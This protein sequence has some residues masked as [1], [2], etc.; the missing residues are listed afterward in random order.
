[1]ALLRSRSRY[2]RLIVVAAILLGLYYISSQPALKTSS[3]S[4]SI[5]AASM[6]RC[7][8][9]PDY[10]P[11]PRSARKIPPDSAHTHEHDIPDPFPL[12][13][14]IPPPSLAELNLAGRESKKTH[15]PETPLLIG[16][17]RNWPQLLQCVVSYLAAGW[18][19]GDI[20]VVEN[21]GVMHANRDGRLGLQ[22]PFYLSHTQL[23]MLGVRVVVTPTLFTF[24]Q[25]Q[26][27]YAWTALE[28]NWTEYFWSHQDL[29]VFSPENSTRP[30]DTL[31][32]RAASILSYLRQPGV[33]RWANHFFAYDHL[34][35]VRRDAILDVGGW[36]THIPYYA[37]DCD[38]Y[39][40]LM[41][42]GY[43]QGET[44]I[45]II[46]D[47]A[48][49]M[50]DVGALLRIP[51]IYAAFQGDPGPENEANQDYPPEEERRRKL[52]GEHG[53]TWDHLVEI[54]RR[55]ENVKYADGGG[56]RN[57][58]QLRQ[59]GG[60]GE[61]F[62]RDPEGFE[63]G[64]RMMIDT[65]RSVF[66]EKWGHRGCDI[67]EIGLGAEDAWKVER[68]WDPETEGGGSE[69]DDW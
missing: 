58:W 52:I 45:G 55:M 65:G 51:G 31:H 18:P 25:L 26:N 64:L 39:D 44:N 56:W 49:V 42:A 57:M 62:Y 27:F 66:A 22:N 20:W 40:R 13:S 17:T 2:G 67:A 47:V 28:R 48:S 23:E 12:L 15:E 46:L 36:D 53:E 5:S 59:T 7:W 41:W 11:R 29:L 24:A 38:M 30:E 9:P 61:P 35:L 63:T 50:D 68:D 14:R 54:G 8:K 34:T 21:T 6:I 10:V 16:F 4:F 19:A 32:A 43:W 1:M 69:G 37:T 3:S 60:Q 33:P